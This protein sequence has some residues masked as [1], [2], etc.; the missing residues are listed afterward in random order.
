M[1]M[2]ENRIIVHS[3]FWL[4]PSFWEIRKMKSFIN[5]LVLIS[6]LI[7]AS[8][9]AGQASSPAG[10]SADSPVYPYTAEVTGNDVF[11]RSG[12]GTNYYT[13]GKLQQG[14]KLT[15]LGA[16]FSWSRIVPPE[17]SFSWISMQYVSIDPENP[18]TGIVTANAVRVFAGSERVR[19]IHSTSLQ[20]KLDRGEKVKLLGE[21]S[22]NYYKIEP[23]AIAYLWV[24]TN[25]IKP[26]VPPIETPEVSEEPDEPTPV[27]PDEPVDTSDAN[28]VAE[29]PE[30]SAEANEPAVTTPVE[31]TTT[32]SVEKEML[33][34]YK[35]LVRQIKA[36]QTKPMEERDYSRI[37]Q[38]LLEIANNPAAG[39][40]VKYSEYV[41][42]QIE[43]FELAFAIANQIQLQEA[44]LKKVRQNIRDAKEARLARI[45]DL[46][47]YAVTGT[48][49]ESAIYG[50]AAKP[51][52]RVTGEDGKTVC[53]ATPL[54]SISES[55]I[56][57]LI[58]KK[59]GLVGSIKPHPQTGT[60]LVSFTDIAEVD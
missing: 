10:T 21:Q 49:K 52:Y 11:I 13:C 6:L 48:L 39:K 58:G 38:D 33:D 28:D 37:K 51:Y 60:A 41:L 9:C 30:E 31:P 40:A 53:Y 44:Q 18:D 3:G 57:K 45:E 12:P 17:G 50:G 29:P 47:K 1:S 2:G 59:V 34:R 16:Q 19:P 43:R 14:D 24:S 46:G 7:G 4:R 36:E 56:G 42:K 27:E 5:L 26:Y 54:G 23:P 20:G 25:F 55:E 15:V 22:D 35:E 32:T 8:F